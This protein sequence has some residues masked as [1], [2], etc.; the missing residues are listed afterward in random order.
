M[1]VLHVWYELQIEIPIKYVLSYV[2]IA[3]GDDQHKIFAKT[4]KTI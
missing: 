2:L 4:H 1:K 3:Q